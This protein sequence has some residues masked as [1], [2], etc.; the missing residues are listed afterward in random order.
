M[1]NLT[2]PAETLG[3][4]K[5]DMPWSCISIHRLIMAPRRKTNLVQEASFSYTVFQC[6]KILQQ[7]TI[8]AAMWGQ[9]HDNISIVLGPYISCHN[10]LLTCVHIGHR[11]IY[12]TLSSRRNWHVHTRQIG[13][14]QLKRIIW[15]SFM[16]YLV[17]IFIIYI[18]MSTFL[19]WSIRSLI[20]PFHSPF[21]SCAP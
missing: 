8:T 5:S 6:L 13:F 14:L 17:T 15:I 11:K 7:C 16:A 4:M 21:G 1:L 12:S 10:F 19:T 20:I 3:W 18:V 9:E 2:F